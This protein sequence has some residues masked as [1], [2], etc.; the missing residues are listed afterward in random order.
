MKNCS[1]ISISTATLMFI[2]L[3]SGLAH[4]ASR[5]NNPYPIIVKI[6]TVD[7]NPTPQ[8]LRSS[9][10]RALLNYHWQVKSVE[11][12]VITATHKDALVEVK[13]PDEQT[14]E[15]VTKFKVDSARNRNWTKKLTKW[16]NNLKK[17]ILVELQYYYF[18]QQF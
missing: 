7:L 16:T 18:M 13:F 5:N 1:P 2:L 17:G 11:N 12:N 10:V 6:E 15:L 4:A 8:Q 14:I 3:F 9:A